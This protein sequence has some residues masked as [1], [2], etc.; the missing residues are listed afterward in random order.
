MNCTILKVSFSLFMTLKE[1]IGQINS[2]KSQVD[3]IRIF[4]SMETSLQYLQT[5]E[6]KLRPLSK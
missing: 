3:L 2:K 4:Q 6:D 5:K 1:D